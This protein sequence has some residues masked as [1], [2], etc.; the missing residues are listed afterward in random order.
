MGV[1]MINTFKNNDSNKALKKSKSKVIKKKSKTETYKIYVYKVLKQLH[2]DTGISSKAMSIMNSFL[3]D[4][5]DKIATEASRLSLY[6]KKTNYNL[7]RN[8][9]SRSF[10]SSRGSCQARYIRGYKSCY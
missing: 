8:S 4:M 6:N 3:N 10:G 2:P 9:V 1:F 7:S 5:F